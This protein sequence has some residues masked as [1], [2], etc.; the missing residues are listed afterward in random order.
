[1]RVIQLWVAALAL[2]LS[3][4]SWFGPSLLCFVV[5]RP[6]EE[7]KLLAQQFLE[8][9]SVFSCDD[10]IIFS[11]VSGEDLFYGWKDDW[12]LKRWPSTGPEV[13]VLDTSLDVG[14]GGAYDGPLNIPIYDEAWRKVYADGRYT[15]HD[16]TIKL[17]LCTV[18]VPMTLKNVLRGHCSPDSPS[19]CDGTIITN[20]GPNLH[21]PVEALTSGAVQK[22]GEQGLDFCQKEMYANWSN[23]SEDAYLLDC[24]K[25][26]AG[27]TV[28]NKPEPGLLV[29]FNL[30]PLPGGGSHCDTGHGAFWEFNDWGGIMSCMGQAG[31]SA[32]VGAPNM[33]AQIAWTKDILEPDNF[34]KPTMFCWALIQPTGQEPELVKW[35]RLRG[36]GIFACDDW[37]LISNKTARQVLGGQAWNTAINEL[38]GDVSAQRTFDEI[39]GT[40]VS[41]MA[42]SEIYLKAWQEVFADGRYRQHDWTLKLDV[43]V[44]IVPHRLRDVLHRHCLQEEES[45]KAKVL[46]NFG[47]DL[48]GPVEA[49]TLEAVESLEQGLEECGSSINK[50]QS[51]F[52]FLDACT[53]KLGIVRERD[54]NLL[55]DEHKSDPRLCDSIHGAFAPF[56]AVKDYEYCMQSTGYYYIAAPATTTYTTTKTSTSVTHTSTSRTTT[57]VSTTTVTSTIPQVIA[58]SIWYFEGE[59]VAGELPPWVITFQ[60]YGN[61][62]PLAGGLLLGVAFLSGIVASICWFIRQRSPPAAAVPAAPA[63]AEVAETTVAQREISQAPSEDV[64]ASARN[65]LLQGETG[66]VEA[67][68]ASSSAGNAPGAASGSADP[69]TVE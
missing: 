58:E 24:F 11:S 47:G 62:Y 12:G 41:V 49:L 20:D 2:Q 56:P 32:Q 61:G 45:C 36:L 30:H 28:K 64:E 69:S 14:T 35:Q 3:A 4:A 15:L 29:D 63:D 21:S 55:S 18:I 60:N 25:T 57:T 51:E 50:G 37:M 54:S 33:P 42:N 7:A 66:D 19:G 44:A 43:D 22:L 31:Y 6:G 10:Y 34:V 65:P 53:S 27:N 40:L 16:W 9:I 59:E 26:F 13:Q 67:G 48:R 39:G 23:Q 46:M 17:E 8:G 5:V 1:M 38:V 52:Q 68:V